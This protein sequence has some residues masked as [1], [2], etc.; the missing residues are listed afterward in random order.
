MWLVQVYTHF[1]I[2]IMCVLVNTIEEEEPQRH[3]CAK[4]VH[5]YE[6]QTPGELCL[7]EVGEIITEVVPLEHGWCKV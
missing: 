4:I 7:H 5:C 1:H 3:H 2:Q 6:P